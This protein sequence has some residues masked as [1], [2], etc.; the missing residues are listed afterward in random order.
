MI[1]RAQQSTARITQSVVTLATCCL[2]VMGCTPG[3]QDARP[4]YE[5]ALGIQAGVPIHFL[6]P[7]GFRGE[8]QIIEDKQTGAALIQENGRLVINVPASGR[9]VVRSFQPFEQEHRESASFADGTT[10]PFPAEFTTE[11][12]RNLLG[13]Y[14][15]G[16]SRGGKYSQE[17]LVYFLGTQEELERLK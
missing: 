1:T 11:V 6:V 2:I 14:G 4:D 9:V 16:F 8:I 12:P 10:I 13:F 7:T 15:G 17:T 5:K 3:S